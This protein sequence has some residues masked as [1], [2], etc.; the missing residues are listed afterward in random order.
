M[1]RNTLKSI[2]FIVNSND[3]LTEEFVGHASTPQNTIG[4]HL[5]LINANKISSEASDL[6]KNIVKS[7][8]E[9]RLV[10]GSPFF[11]ELLRL[12]RGARTRIISRC[13]RLTLASAAVTL[14]R[15]SWLNLCDVDTQLTIMSTRDDDRVVFACALPMQSCM[16]RHVTNSVT[17]TTVGGLA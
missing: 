8:K 12:Y 4:K 14:R 7:L 2:L 10:I 9:F 6:P 13:R 5:V 16:H 17:L 1:A 3:C 15:S 11:N